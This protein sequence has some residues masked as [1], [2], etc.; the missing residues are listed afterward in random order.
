MI[1]RDCRETSWFAAH[2]YR[3]GIAFQVTAKPDASGTFCEG[4]GHQ[5]VADIN[6]GRRYGVLIGKVFA[7]CDANIVKVLR[8]GITFHVSAIPTTFAKYLNKVI[9]ITSGFGI[10]LEAPDLA[11]LAGVSRYSIFDCCLLLLCESPWTLLLNT[12]LQCTKPLCYSF[13]ECLFAARFPGLLRSYAPPC[14]Q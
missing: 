12:I 3:D 11:I 8:Y 5:D 2:N 13:F 7:C 10:K 14:E 4:Q 6:C 1:R 9:G